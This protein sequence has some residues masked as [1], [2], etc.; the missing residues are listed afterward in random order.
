ML[1]G[2]LF[3]RATDIFTKLVELQELGVRIEP[4]DA[5][6][7]ECGE[8]LQEA[9]ELGK[10]VLHRSGEEGIDE[11]WGEPFKAFSFPVEEFYKSRYVK[12][13]H[14]MRCIDEIC[15]ALA[16]TLTPLPAFAGIGPLLSDFAHAA[17]LK[18]ETLRTEPDIFDVWAS[19]VVAGENLVGF[20]PRLPAHASAAEQQ[21][22]ARGVQLL[23]RGRNLISDVAR[24]RVPMPKTSREFALACRRYAEVQAELARR[25]TRPPSRATQHRARGAVSASSSVK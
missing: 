19:F 14:T 20:E 17:K 24:A 11:L 13:A 6:M 23:V 25:S 22:A 7:Q 9:L 18:C 1:A 16:T 8:H 2:A 21:R 12:I 10:T 5:L 15:E 4:G 3:N